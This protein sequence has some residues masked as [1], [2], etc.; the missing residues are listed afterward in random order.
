MANF[1]DILGYKVVSP[2]LTSLLHTPFGPGGPRVS[3]V[4]HPLW[5]YSWQI[6]AHTHTH[7]RQAKQACKRSHLLTSRVGFFSCLP[8]SRY[9]GHR[10]HSDRCVDSWHMWSSLCQILSWTWILPPPTGRHV[11]KTGFCHLKYLNPPSQVP[12]TCLV[13]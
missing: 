7:T 9:R 8:H 6:P 10:D 2:W 3:M 4:L 11:G 1:L 12:L 5:S 13:A